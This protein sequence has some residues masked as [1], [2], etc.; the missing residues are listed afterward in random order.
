MTMQTAIQDFLTIKGVETAEELHQAT[1]LMTSIHCVD[2]SYL[3]RWLES[4]GTT[5]PR[6]KREHTRIALCNGELA[7][8]L[9]ISTDTFRI[10]EAR[11][12]MGGLG[13]VSIAPRFQN[14]NIRETLISG[15][16]E[17]LKEH[18]YHVAMCFAPSREYEPFGFVGSM[19]DYAVHI[20]CT[21]TLGPEKLSGRVRPVKP[22]DIGALQRMQTLNSSNTSCSILRER[23][24]F[25]NQWETFKSATVFT[26]GQGKIEGYLKTSTDLEGLH[27]EEAEAVGEAAFRDIISYAFDVAK[28]G[29][30]SQLVYHGPP[31][32]P[33]MNVL[34]SIVSPEALR[35]SSGT[36]GLV[37]IT[38]VEETLESMIP[39]WE[40]R[41]HRCL[42][43]EMDCEVTLI[44]ENKAY[45]I[46]VRFGAVDIALQSGRNKFSVDRGVFTQL[47][48]GYKGIAEVWPLKRRLVTREGRAL[49]ETL[50]PKRDPYMALFDRF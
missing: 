29:L 41:V 20:H 4:H 35:L 5:Y 38:D 8:T 22:G 45:R 34:S 2:S 16:L 14:G 49:L 24:H 6:F 27:I 25:A 13:W 3:C 9:R 31:D 15:T 18:R 47:L 19:S 46:R 48:N 28:D 36:A 21:K 43:R 37:R 12:K 7:G 33:F 40:S 42:L 44:I 39:E 26:N 50:F 32:H 1:T 11:L 23:A 10:G 17:Y 30:I